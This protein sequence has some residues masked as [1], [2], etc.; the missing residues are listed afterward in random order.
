MC[1]LPA[2]WAVGGELSK[3]VFHVLFGGLL[4]GLVVVRFR[5]WLQ[6]CPPRQ[7]IDIRRFTRE[8]SRMVY[9]V[10]YLVVGSQQVIRFVGYLQSNHHVPQSL[11]VLELPIDGQAFLICGLIAIVLIRVLAFCR[12]RRLRGFG[13]PAAK[14]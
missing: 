8:L 12:W 11:D 9:L 13:M 7:A 10:L 3:V 5:W 6:H 4:C 14:R 1:L 2:P